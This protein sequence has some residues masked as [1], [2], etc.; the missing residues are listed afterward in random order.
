MHHVGHPEDRLESDA[1]L[2]NIHVLLAPIILRALANAAKRLD[3]F[4]VEAEFVAIDAENAP[5]ERD[6]KRRPD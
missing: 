6:F 5:Y 3:V 2:S 4:P 1:F